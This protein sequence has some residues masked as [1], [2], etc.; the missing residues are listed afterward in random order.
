VAGLVKDA[1]T[2]NKHLGR[3]GDF[4]FIWSRN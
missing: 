2:K 1:K 4:H 3:Q